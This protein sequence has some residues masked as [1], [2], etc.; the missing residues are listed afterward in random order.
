M[1]FTKQVWIFL[2]VLGAINGQFYHRSLF[3]GGFKGGEDP[4]KAEICTSSV[5]SQQNCTSGTLDACC[6]SDGSAEYACPPEGLC[7]RAR[8][9]TCTT[10][11]DCCGLDECKRNQ[12]CNDCF[13]SHARVQIQGKGEIFISQLQRGDKVLTANGYSPV[14]AFGSAL[15]DTQVRYVRLVTATHVLELS[16]LHMLFVGKDRVTK[17]AQNVQVGDELVLQPSNEVS[18][19]VST[20]LHTHEGAYTPYTVDGTIVVNGV[21]ASN[22]ASWTPRLSVAGLEILDMHQLKYM[23][24]SPGRVACR[25]SPTY[26]CPHHRHKHQLWYSTVARGPTEYLADPNQPLNW[27][28]TGLGWLRLMGMILVVIPIYVAEMMVDQAGWPVVVL[29]LLLGAYALVRRRRC[30]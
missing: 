17:Y 19:V 29:T 2:F 25:L 24:L 8:N 14:Y 10:D 11:D 3:T 16:P 18:R 21:L 20:S 23:L 1:K 12:R 5:F 15:A 27:M 22:H 30:H 6:F 9:E 7:C 26:G 28:T 13:P 4:S